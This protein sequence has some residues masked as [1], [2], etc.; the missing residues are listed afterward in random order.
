[1]TDCV[2]QCW[3]CKYNPCKW[4]NNKQRDKINCSYKLCKYFSPLKEFKHIY[5]EID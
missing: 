4:F 5:K 2:P 1:M 3:T